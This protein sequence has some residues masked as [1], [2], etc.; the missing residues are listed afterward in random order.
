[1]FSLRIDGFT[2]SLDVLYKGLVISKLQV[3]VKKRYIKSSTV[4]GFF[5]LQFLVIKTLDADPDPD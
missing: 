3:L 4:A 2:C 5:F 1:M